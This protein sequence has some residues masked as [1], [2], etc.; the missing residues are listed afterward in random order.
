MKTRIASFLLV[1]VMLFGALSLSVS[2]VTPMPTLQSYITSTLSGYPTG[3]V[4]ISLPSDTIVSEATS[5]PANITVYVGPDVKLYVYAAL[6]VYGELRSALPANIIV[7]SGG[8]VTINNINYWNPYN[9]SVPTLQYYITSA[10]N[11]NPT[12]NITINLP[13]DA[14][15]SAA[16]TIP[17][18]VTVNVGSGVRLF[19]YAPLTVNGA[20]NTAL[21]SNII[22]GVGGSVTINGINYW[23]P[24]NPS[25]P[26]LQYYI[27]SALTANPTGNITINLP[28]DAIVSAATT[29][30]SNV[31]VYVGPNVRLFVYAPLTVNGTLNTALSSNIIVGV[32]GSV[33]VNTVNYWDPYYYDYVYIPGYGYIAINTACAAPT[34]SIASGSVVE[35]DT[36]VTLSSTTPGAVIYY[37]AD[38]TVPTASSIKYTEP[39]AINRNMV[40]RA[41]AVRQYLYNSTVSVFAYN[42]KVPVASSTFKDIKDYPKLA[43]S[44]DKLLA[45]KVISSSASFNPAGTVS[46]D[47]V[48]SWFTKLGVT[49]ADAKINSATAFKDAGK[50]TYE[51]MIYACYKIMRS[52]KLI[53]TPRKQ[54]SVTLKL[55]TYN[56]EITGTAIYKAA[57]C[58]LIENNVLYGLSFHPQDQANRAYLAT[59]VA[60]ASG[61]VK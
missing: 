14:I 46:W 35:E 59:I 4:I 6:T 3:N 39:I 50:L 30:P 18:N 52:D 45:K 26:T 29:I 28:S 60:W 17:S 48:S 57:Y 19:V 11:A 33:T 54:G 12:G 9:P 56:S 16:T 55:L 1:A 36:K 58:S 41:I 10:L 13:G 61:K 53:P 31:T 32:G 43:V 27:T 21:S 47:D 8:S 7:D 42:V 34:A 2:A 25:V 40:I 15:V 5:I 51:D 22:I 49:V 24:Y 23:N 20:L 44:L 38:G 37:T